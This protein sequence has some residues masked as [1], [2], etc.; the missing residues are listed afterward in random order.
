M[1]RKLEL[2]TVIGF[3]GKPR[4]ALVCTRFNEMNYLV[5]SIGSTLVLKNMDDPS[6]QTFLQGHS[7]RIACMALHPVDSRILASGQVTHM[8]FLA[9]ILVWDLEARAI[10]CTLQLHKVSVAALAFSPSGEFLASIGGEDDNNLVVWHVDVENARGIAICGA[11]AAHDIALAVVWAKASD[12]TLITA[13]RENLRVWNFDVGER[14]VRP[15]D[16]QLGQTRRCFTCLVVSDDDKHVYA[17]TETGDVLE[18]SISERLLRRI[19]PKQRIARQITAAALDFNGNLVLGSGDALT[20]IT[21]DE[22]KVV[23]TIG[24]DQISGQVTSITA[25]PSGELLIGTTVSNVYAVQYARHP[26][27]KGAV[28]DT[29]TLKSTCHNDK[30]NDV[31]F[32]RGYSEL[33]ATCSA[34]DIRIWH[35]ASASELL[36]IQVPNLEC[37]VIAFNPKGSAIISGWSDGKVRAFGPQSGKLL[38]V[39]NDAH[40]LVGVGNPSGGTVPANG[41]TALCVTN[42][43]S[44]LITGGADGQVRV[45][46]LDTGA[47]VMI[48]SMKEHK[49]PVND[50]RM[51]STDVECLSA[52]ADGSVIKWSLESF[53][54]IA[55][56]FGATFF[57]AVCYHPDESQFISC[58]T[59]HKITFWDSTDMAAVRILEGS[60]TAALNGLDISADG[61]FYV[62]ASADRSVK[63]WHYD[64]GVCWYTGEGHSSAVTKVKIS[65]DEQRLVSIGNDA[66][67]CIWKLPE[68]ATLF[69]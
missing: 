69:E 66:S 9:P 41:V 30:I 55:A 24:A 19:G 38:Y 68:R 1:E 42:A 27:G 57:T 17:A 15:I 45:W 28:L 23:A 63:L 54:R 26:S 2:E 13:G 65:P 3:S 32:P 47:Q 8:G 59:D 25:A 16:C 64:E 51:G 20:V 7:D 60:Q 6:D 21:P 58:G 18:V 48:A 49:G 4:G 35:L 29:V 37:N 50:L 10:V 62:S 44:R 33:F 12:D 11:P 14:K 39:I 43:G 22:F 5:H 40:K 61:S 67:I 34:A 46:K 52:S 56:V 31:A 36:R 53:T